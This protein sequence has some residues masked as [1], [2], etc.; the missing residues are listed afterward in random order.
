MPYACFPQGLQIYPETIPTLKACFYGTGPV[1]THRAIFVLDRKDYK[2][3]GQEKARF[4]HIYFFLGNKSTCSSSCVVTLPPLARLPHS[5]V[6]LWGRHVRMCDLQRG[7]GVHRQLERGGGVHHQL[8]R[9]GGVHHQLERGSGVHHQRRSSSQLEKGGGV[10]HYLERGEVLSSASNGKKKI[11]LVP[12][13][14]SILIEA[15]QKCVMGD[16]TSA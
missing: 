15:S 7:G 6:E 16:Q 9:A 10:H 2:R 1:R 11:L 14:G 4:A 3:S 12:L 8:E 13:S 5:S